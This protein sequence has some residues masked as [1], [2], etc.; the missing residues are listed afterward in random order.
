M[1]KYQEYNGPMVKTGLTV[2]YAA[3]PIRSIFAISWT[4]SD[5]ASEAEKKYKANNDWA[6]TNP[7]EWTVERA[8][9]I[10]YR[11]GIRLARIAQGEEQQGHL[12]E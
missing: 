3:F 1:S 2:M 6:A 5:T 4:A 8:V 7:S 10:K 12:E 11:R 9:A